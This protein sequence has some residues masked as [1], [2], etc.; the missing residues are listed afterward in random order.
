MGG[1]PL[2][3]ILLAMNR[4]E[5]LRNIVETYHKHGWQL[6]RALLKPA[7]EEPAHEAMLAGVEIVE[8]E[9]DALWFARPSHE[10]REAWELRWLNATPYALFETFEADEEEEDRA[11]ARREMEARLR[12]HASGNPLANL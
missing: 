10:G 3:S 9:I 2:W 7:D 12:D 4:L 6:R 5:L 1:P 8:C 11:D